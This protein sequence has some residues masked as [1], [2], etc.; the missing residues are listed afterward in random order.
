MKNRRERVTMIP[1]AH[2]YKTYNTCCAW[3]KELKYKVGGVKL[4]FYYV[5]FR[6]EFRVVM[7]VTIFA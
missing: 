5:S 3:P 7:S 2:T 1:L 4:L 6:S